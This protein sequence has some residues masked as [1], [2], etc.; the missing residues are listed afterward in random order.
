MFIQVSLQFFWLWP[1]LG[2]WIDGKC[3]MLVN[4][5]GRALRLPGFQG[6]FQACRRFSYF[7]I[8][9]G[10]WGGALSD[11]LNWIPPHA[12]VPEFVLGH[13][14]PLF[15]WVLR[16]IVE[17][18]SSHNWRALSLSHKIVS[19]KVCGLGRIQICLQF[20]SVQSLSHAWLFA[21]PWITVCQASLSITN[22]WSALKLMSIESVM[23][24]NHLILCYP[25]LL[26]S[27]IPPSIRDFSNETTLRMRWPKYWSFS[28]SIIPFKE[29]LGL[30]SF[31]NS[32]VQKHQ[33]FS[34][35]LSSQSNSH[36]H[37]WLLEKP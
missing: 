18:L 2:Q 34:A 14:S 16:R 21:T 37:T 7:R 12:F 19:S 30:I 5:G 6:I 23:P 1:R 29:H 4:E 20:N 32:T 11:F 35:Q 27:S 36:I 28:F 3:I 17:L 22:S 8:W 9:A 26:L 33:F 10:R 13:V 24:S 15:Q 31:S 25:L